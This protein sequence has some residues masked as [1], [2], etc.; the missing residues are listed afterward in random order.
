MN[1]KTTKTILLAIV[2]LSTLNC[3]STTRT[4]TSGNGNADAATA[5]TVAD[6]NTA[7]TIAA[8]AGGA[9]QQTTP[10]ALVKD[11]YKTHDA[12]LK[13]SSDRI[14]SGKSRNLLDKYFDKPLAD[15]IW[16]DL[17]TNRDEV[18]VLDFDPFYNAQ[19][20]GI[21]NLNIESPKT[22]GEKASVGVTFQN[23]DRKDTLIY[24]LVRRGA[25][26]KIADIKYADGSTLAGYFR[27]DAK[28]KNAGDDN[29]GDDENFFAGTYRVG[30]TTCTVKPIKMAFEVRWAKGSGAMIF[31]FDGDA[32]AGKYT[33]SS[34]DGGK[35]RDT[36]VF[37][38]DT[39]TNGKFIRADGR[40][41][42]I[43]KVR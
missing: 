7:E 19:D 2:L 22:E 11:L 15:F 21:K 39:F 4:E 1:K 23:Y 34:E 38:D 17:T 35:G 42:T 36:F 29:S 9:A 13:S 3:V 5:Q 33:Y 18:G 8:N 31:V 14:L 25:A 27:Q 16:K 6:E 12:D 37:D 43:S 26:W 40:E 24:T 20:V 32:T 41:M 28:S 30:S 10:D